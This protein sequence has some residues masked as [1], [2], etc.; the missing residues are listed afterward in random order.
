MLRTAHI[1]LFI[2]SL[3]IAVSLMGCGPA[4][5]PDEE[6]L[7]TIQAALTRTPTPTPLPNTTVVPTAM[8]TQAPTP[9][10]IPPT[11]T[12]TPIPPTATSVPNPTPTPVPTPTPTH[13]PGDVLYQ[14]DWSNG[15]NGWAGTPDWNHV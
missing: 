12:P 8:P 11:P 1:S 3:L 14:A 7:K 9:T 4:Q 13:K 2:G 15:M 10:P 6:A 5:A